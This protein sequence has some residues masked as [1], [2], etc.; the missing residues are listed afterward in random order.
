MEGTP[1]LLREYHGKIPL[2]ER[3]ENLSLKFIIIEL[4]T[5][6]KIPGE[7]I[8][9]REMYKGYKGFGEDSHKSIVIFMQHKTLTLFAFIVQYV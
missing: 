5:I 1:P 9:G 6:V 4:P 7:Q 8:S 3:K 2:A